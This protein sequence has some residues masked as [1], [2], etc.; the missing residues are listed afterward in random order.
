MRHAP[1]RATLPAMKTATPKQRVIV[2]AA[3]EN[4]VIRG[5]LTA[6]SGARR[7]FHVWLELNTA[8]EALLGVSDTRNPRGHAGSMTEQR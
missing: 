8:L 3:I 7:D 1:G 2:D 5:T 4:S 6:P